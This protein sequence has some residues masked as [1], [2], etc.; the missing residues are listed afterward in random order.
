MFLFAFIFGVEIN[1][2]N[3]S[4]Q[5]ALAGALFSIK[6]FLLQDIK[7]SNLQTQKLKLYKMK[8]LFKV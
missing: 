4:A 5:S 3:W 6:E 1:F 7:I 2:K 8:L